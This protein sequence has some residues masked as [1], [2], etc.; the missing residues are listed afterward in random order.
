[1]TDNLEFDVTLNETQARAQFAALAKEFD[2]PIDLKVDFNERQAKAALKRIT[3]ELKGTEVELRARITF[4]QRQV[5][6]DV[7]A[8]KAFI[9]AEVGSIDIKADFDA[10]HLAGQIQD[11]IDNGPRVKVKLDA[12]SVNFP[13]GGVRGTGAGTRLPV[14]KVAGA[15]SGVS[16]AKAELELQK[17]SLALLTAQAK[18]QEEAT[19]Q[20]MLQAREAEKAAAARERESATAR[21]NFRALEKELGSLADAQQAEQDRRLK[22]ELNLVDRRAKAAN[23]AFGQDEKR[24]KELAALRLKLLEADARDQLAALREREREEARAATAKERA[25]VRARDNFRSL[26]SELQKLA[27]ASEAAQQKQE[28][29]NAKNLADNIRLRAAL[30]KAIIQELKIKEPSEAE[31]LALNAKIQAS[32]P[33]IKQEVKLDVDKDLLAIFTGAKSKSGGSGVGGATKEVDGLFKTIAS[34]APQAGAQL[35]GF[36]HNLAAI[37]KPGGPAAVAGIGLA[38]FLALAAATPAITFVAGGAVAALAGVFAGFG[39]TAA[40]E[41][42]PVIKALKGIDDGADGLTEKFSKEFGSLKGI[43]AVGFLPIGNQIADELFNPLNDGLARF[44]DTL[45][46]SVSRSLTLLAPAIEKLALTFAG[47]FGTAVGK[48]TEEF[49]KLVV[50]VLPKLTDGRLTATFDQLAVALERSGPGIEKT[51]D[52]LID[53]L[54]VIVDNLPELIEV[55]TVVLEVADGLIKVVGAAKLL[56]DLN[57]LAAVVATDKDQE[58]MSLFNRVLQNTA[59]SALELADALGLLGPS[60]FVHAE[61]SSTESELSSLG[62]AAGGVGAKVD[63]LSARILQ[64][65]KKNLPV[66]PKRIQDVVDQI[67]QFTMQSQEGTITAD[68]LNGSLRRLAA[69]S[70]LSVDEWKL[71]I[72][73]WEEGTKAAEDQAKA[74]EKL[75]GELDKINATLGTGTSFT[76]LRIEQQVFFSE[77]LRDSIVTVEEFNAVMLVTG[78][79]ADQVQAVFQGMADGVKEIR[80]N[81]LSTIPTFKSVTEGLDLSTIAFGRRTEA[82]LKKLRTDLNDTLAFI[83]DVKL[84]Q[85]RGISPD[86]LSAALTLP[87]E[88]SRIVIRELAVGGP[89]QLALLESRYGDI[90]ARSQWARDQLELIAKQ[91]GVKLPEELTKGLVE[92]A[93]K[94]EKASTGIA[95]AIKAGV[96]AAGLVG[97]AKNVDKATGA[98]EAFA[99]KAATDVLPVLADINAAVRD[100]DQ[101]SATIDIFLNFDSVESGAEAVALV[102]SQLDSL[103]ATIDVKLGLDLFFA[104]AQAVNQVLDQIAG[105]TVKVDLGVSPPTFNFLAREH[106]G[107]V[108]PGERF[109]VNEA[110]REGIVDS[111]GFRML[112][113]G[114]YQT[115]DRPGVIIPAD[116]VDRYVG[117]MQP[118]SQTTTTTIDRRST[119]THGPTTIQ[120]VG[121][122]R[123]PMLVARRIARDLP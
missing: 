67:G 94:V 81:L 37:G 59:Q 6:R 102:V 80:D 69:A 68:Q 100:T 39:V 52:V 10:P 3:T 121:T 71:A 16:A 17:L 24:E 70:G 61:L 21:A 116:Q 22:D 106:G 88:Q 58:N 89:E 57:P 38:G 122:G 62:K 109:P 11:A 115:F 27:A 29:A 111:R 5:I 18:E 7:T 86:L 103:S 32:F 78:L 82:I 93:P 25:D 53:L 72:K 30:E 113:P 49:T 96:D 110:G 35:L 20:V 1:M 26:S 120:V 55:G 19:K 77:A 28:R 87:F 108:W 14:E 79:G 92:G 84:A 40:A 44:T 60:K 123:D 99:D 9:E 12:D 114:G 95:N 47:P 54:D 36:G 85:E 74:V 64:L 118:G 90:I 76:K 65:N 83:G 13:P 8:L 75:Q 46:P 15:P 63:D 91:T 112:P 42:E 117:P 2:K 23:V 33:N 98:I 105:R 48:V 56:D 43:L 4:N 107:W 73:A 119:T 101:L 97:A 104:Q 34:G 41:M 45:A 51:A 66:L 50:L 31:L